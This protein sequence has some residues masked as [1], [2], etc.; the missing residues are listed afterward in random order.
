LA[1]LANVDWSSWDALDKAKAIMADFGVEI[2]TSSDYWK[3]FATNMRIANN[4][5]PD[6]TKLQE[7]L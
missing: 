6:F 4:S 2:D 5:V 1:Q 3:N 7:N